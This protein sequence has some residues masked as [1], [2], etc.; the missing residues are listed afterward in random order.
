MWS[1][2]RL[3]LEVFSLINKVRILEQGSSG[4][5]S[6]IVVSPSGNLS[7]DNVQDALE[8]LQGDIDAFVG[9]GDMLKSMYDSNNN[10]IVDAAE[11]VPWSGVT[12]KP[13]T[14]T[15]SS[16]THPASEITDF[17]TEVSNNSDVSANTSARHTHS[18]QATLDAIT[19]A[20]TIAQETKLSGIETNADVT[21]AA[22]VAAA[23]AVMESDTSTALMNFVI[24]EDDMSSNSNTKVPT[25]QSVKAYVDNNITTLADVYPVGCIYISTVST[26]PGT[27]FGFGTWSAFAP[28]RVLV[29][30]DAEQSEFNT[31]EETG[32]TK[33]HT[34]TVNEMPSHT[35]VQDAHTHNFFGRDTTTGALSS[36]AGAT[37]TSSSLLSTNT[38]HVQPATAVNQ[39]TGGGQAHN[40]LQPY[41]TVYMFKRTA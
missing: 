10:N 15:P 13:S 20:F 11:S 8:E 9:G 5:A 38:N 19:A 39:N 6:D 16:H 25:Q 14:F 34:L 4:Q 36:I 41:I 21:D 40:N 35:H 24:D 17:D 7:S 23:G 22:N 27:L 28:G 29:G 3:K 37:D 30:I 33:T 2:E 26:N 12:G 1:F 31:V 18:N 32:G